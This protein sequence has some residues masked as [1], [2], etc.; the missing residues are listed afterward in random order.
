MPSIEK[1]LHAC[2]FCGSNESK[3]FRRHLSV[4]LEEKSD[5]AV[6]C[7]C[8][9]TGP[10]EDSKEKAIDAWNSRDHY[11]QYL[12]WN[13]FR[14]P[15]STFSVDL[16]GSLKSLG[17]STILQILSSENKTGVL[18]LTHGRTKRAICLKDGKIIAASGKEGLRL[19]QFLCDQERIS[20]KQLQEALE[21]AR[22]TGRRVGEVL[23]DLGYISENSLK[24]LIRHQIREAVLEISLWLEGD[25]EYRDCPVDFDERGV[26]DINTMGI[27]LE[28][29]RVFDEWVAAT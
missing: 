1:D 15:R 4:A 11:E 7:L 20:H 23:L 25:F 29:A 16:K 24:E 18:L 2:P 21:R 8:G 6:S 5:F 19:G 27:I 22:E 3:G 13:P 28:A 9:A 14:L 12:L 26:E 10:T 17:L